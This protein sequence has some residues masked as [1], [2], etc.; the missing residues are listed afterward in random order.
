ME[1]S[2]WLKEQETLDEGWKDWAKAGA[3]AGGMAAGMFAPNN[4]DAQ[5]RTSVPSRNTSSIQQVTP[6]QHSSSS[7]SQ[8]WTNN[9]GIYTPIK[10]NGVLIKHNLNINNDSIADQKIDF[11]PTNVLGQYSQISAKGSGITQ[12]EA[13]TA[14]L[15][16]A[17]K[18][19]VGVNI[20]ATTVVRNDELEKD[21]IIANGEAAIGKFTIQDIQ[22]KNGI[23]TVKIRVEVQKNTG[24]S[25]GIENFRRLGNDG[26]FR[27]YKQ[28]IR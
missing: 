25:Q 14:A 12:E 11:V 15:E 16:D 24:K 19:V 3:L 18:Q 21:Q 22:Q 20:K 5:I 13:I 10:G 26:Q 2:Q 7:I 17:A 6:S 4:A 23:I 27:T 9:G 28:T 1:F 8:Y